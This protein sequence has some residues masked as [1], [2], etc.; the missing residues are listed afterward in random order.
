MLTLQ[1]GKPKNRLRLDPSRA[2]EPARKKIATLEAQR[3]M[4]VFEETIKRSEIVTLMPFILENLSRFNVVFGAELVEA[5]EQHGSIKNSY[6][7]IRNQ[8]EK[9]RQRREKSSDSLH[10]NLSQAEP[11]EGPDA[12]EGESTGEKSRPQSHYS[13]HSLSASESQMDNVMRNLSF[14]AQQ[15]STSTKNVLRLFSI[16]PAAISAVRAEV[17][18]RSGECQSFITALEEL[19]EV[20][21]IKLLTTPVEEKEKFD[22]LHEI[23]LRERQNAAHIVKIEAEVKGAQDDRDEE[24]II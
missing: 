7:E 10:S 16:N 3:V 18:E 13:Q 12:D 24:V 23:S 9:M 4:T 19:K 20:L 5:L 17:G 1:T 8:L 22:Y 6:E 2:L 14:V 11:G 21:L 15:L